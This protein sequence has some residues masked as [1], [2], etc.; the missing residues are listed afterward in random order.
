MLNVIG[1]GE[2]LWD[3][4][5]EGKQL[6]GAPCNFV[7]HAFRLGAGARILSA[8]GS[9]EMGREILETVKRKNLSTDL[10]QVND[11]STSTVDVKL[12]SKGVPKYVIHQDVAWDFLY[13]D[14]NA[15]EMVNN[16]DIVCFGSLAQR[17]AT[18]RETIFQFLNVC[19]SD[20]LIIFD[21]N[22]RQTFYNKEIIEN[23]L[24]FCNVLKMNEEEFPIIS[25][26][27][28]LKGDDLDS[29]VNELIKNYDLKLVAF[30]KGMQGSILYTPTK[31]SEMSTPKVDIKDTVGA[32]DSFA[33]AMAIGFANKLPLRNLHEKAIE[34]ASFV[35]ESNGAMPY[36]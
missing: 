19:K 33:A 24:H 9:D 20:A 30:T 36:Y 31:K 17:S 7:Y 27:I 28:N 11:K 32:G 18:S 6:G 5:P 3:L 25:N 2:M 14:E 8:V 34:I 1:I 10:I 29:N 23:S 21:I 35:C 4:L 12:N 26:L 15:I 16:A 22:I 13:F